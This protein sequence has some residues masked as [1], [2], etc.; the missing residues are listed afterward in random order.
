MR[1]FMLLVALF[2][3]PCFAQES[4]VLPDAPRPKPGKVFWIGITSLAIAESFD[5]IET[6]HELN[7]GGWEK[8]PLFGYHPSPQKQGLIDAA[9]FAGES[10]LFYKTER[11]KKW[12]WAG[13]IGLSFDV[14]EHIRY[15]ACG[16]LLKNCYGNG[17]P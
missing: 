4:K 14:G 15:G 10:F 5:A 6:R 9:I 17:L 13:R 8:N 3:M 1:K 7:Y 12:R 11:S 2:A 16:A